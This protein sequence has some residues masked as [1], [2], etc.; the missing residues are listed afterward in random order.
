MNLLIENAGLLELHP[1][2]LQEEQDILIQDK[3]IKAV[4]KGLRNWEGAETPPI[5]RIIDARGRF[6]VPGIV[7]AHNH[8]YSALARGI[9]ANIRPSFDF[10]GI[11]ENL[12]W[13]LDRALDEG[14]LYYSGLV[15]ALDAIKAGTTSVIDHSASPAFITGSLSILKKAFEKC[16]LRGILCYEVTDRNGLDGRDRGIKENVEFIRKY[17]T[18]LIRGALGA[19][20]PFTLGDESLRLLSEARGETGRGIHIHVSE[21]RYDL[22]YSHHHY[23][24][25]A[26]ERLERFHLLDE[27]SL[28]VHGVHLLEKDLDILEQNGSFLVH[29]PRSNM[30]NNVGYNS[31][32]FGFG[33]LAVGTDGIGSDMFEET[34][35]AYFKSRDEGLD[36]SPAD[37]MRFLWNGNGLL[38]RYFET[39]FGRIEPGYC[40]D[41]VI[42]DY[43]SPTPLMENNIAGH[44]MFGLS[45]NSVETVI[46]NGLPVYEEGQFPFDTEQIYRE[47]RKEASELW[48]RMDEL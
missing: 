6:V 17:E 24:I 47:A 34:K 11:L 45:S 26:V 38:E 29:N 15:G 8:F 42:L 21:D 37:F 18:G 20:A 41:L 9:V 27:K 22:S 32:L 36:C 44:F 13:R 48:K 14:S 5:D 1:G 46:I 4:G 16:G 10:V 12:W 31:C 35:F 43:K 40:A 2:M 30:N 19:H 23:G 7:C 25:S 33:N 3:T 28:I 39:N